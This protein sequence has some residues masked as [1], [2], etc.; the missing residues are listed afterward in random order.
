MC[1]V[2]PMYKLRDVNSTFAKL[3]LAVN[4][5][6]E[7]ENPS[8]APSGRGA[9]RMRSHEDWVATDWFP[10]PTHLSILS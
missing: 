5:S 9:K 1:W 4:G 7:S 2:Y 10:P 8:E 6:F 3:I